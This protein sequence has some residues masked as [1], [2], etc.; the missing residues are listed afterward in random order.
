[1]VWLSDWSITGRPPDS[2]YACP[3]T[4]AVRVLTGH[5]VGHPNLEDGDVILSSALLSIHGK[6]ARTV[7]RWYFLAK[8]DPDYE[9][10][11][12]ARG[13]N[14]YPARELRVNEHLKLRTE[15]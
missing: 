1:M 2:P 9:R 14:V 12:N 4:F 3:E 6:Y 7:N 11:M 10:Y 13:K 5:V 8:V 15:S